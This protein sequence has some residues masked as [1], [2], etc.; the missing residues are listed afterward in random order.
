MKAAKLTRPGTGPR[1]IGHGCY[2]ALVEGPE[3][4]QVALGA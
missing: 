2:E 4:V 3:G 1:Q